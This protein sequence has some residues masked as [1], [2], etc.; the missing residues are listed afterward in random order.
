M[1]VHNPSP[2][3]VPEVTM[4]ISS[5]SGSKHCRGAA[6]DFSDTSNTSKD[7][8]E[9]SAS[10]KK[11]LIAVI[12]CVIFMVVEVVGGIKANSLAIL[13][14]AAHLLSDVA[15]HQRLGYVNH[16]IL[17]EPIIIFYHLLSLNHMFVASIMLH[18]LSILFCTYFVF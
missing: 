1:D 17:V 9:R 10:M 8:K 4:D 3:H 14:D 2:P 13:T 7:A 6:Y 18:F 12:L 15:A 11:L 16:T 5:A